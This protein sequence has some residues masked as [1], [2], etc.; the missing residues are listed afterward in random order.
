MTLKSGTPL[1]II[2]PLCPNYPTPHWHFWPSSLRLC[3][4]L[5]VI[6]PKLQFPL[7]C[8]SLTNLIT[9]KM[10]WPIGCCLN[11]MSFCVDLVHTAAFAVTFAIIRSMKTFISK[12]LHEVPKMSSI[13]DTWWGT[14][15]N[16][17]NSLKLDYYCVIINPVGWSYVVCSIL[18]ICW[19]HTGGWA[20]PSGQVEIPQECLT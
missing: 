4:R 16:Q 1:V 11:I 15:N 19:Q 14:I 13:M 6:W 8:N 10:I 9:S 5:A 3:V 2:T 7:L 20:W 17:P 12:T 18:G